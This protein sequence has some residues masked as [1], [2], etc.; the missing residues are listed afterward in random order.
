MSEH[1]DVA[2]FKM[3]PSDMVVILIELLDYSKGHREVP[4]PKMII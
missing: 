3:L 4:S 2:I 1:F